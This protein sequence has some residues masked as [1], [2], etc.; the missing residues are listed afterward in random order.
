M[1]WLVV[2]TKPS[3][4]SLVKILL[5]KQGYQVL[6]PMLREVFAEGERIRPLFPRYLFAE[7]SLENQRWRPISYTR[8]VSRIL[9]SGEDTPSRVPDVWID[10]MK[11]MNAVVER[12]EDALAFKPGQKLQFKEGPFEGREGVCQ[13]TSKERVAILL[14]LLGQNVVVYSKPAQLQPTE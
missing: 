14:S 13:W 11:A 6:L 1:P 8:G 2:Q 10:N 3:S 12:I 7:Y 9:L 5:E 4:E